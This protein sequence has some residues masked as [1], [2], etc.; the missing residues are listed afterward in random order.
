MF[1]AEHM[2]QAH[3]SFDPGAIVATLNRENPLTDEGEYF[4]IWVGV[5]HLPTR[6]LRYATAGHPA[7][8]LTREGQPLQQIG[9]KTWPIGF[10][11][12]EIYK[13]EE[14]Q[15]LP[16]DRLYLFSDGVYE[17]FSPDGELW[18]RKGFEGACQSVH[19]QP[20]KNGLQ[21]IVQQAQTWQQ[22]ETFADDVALVGLE[23][24]S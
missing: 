1:R 22:Q 3:P 16:G 13:T 2:I 19:T 4:T 15:L 14:V 21:W 24:L 12:E 23:I 6:R 5:L 17:V 10:G 7:V 8:V 18:D 11:I 20:L 9:A